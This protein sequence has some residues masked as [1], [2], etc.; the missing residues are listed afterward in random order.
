MTSLAGRLA[1]V[2][3]SASASVSAAARSL[4]A[5]G[6]DIV[7]LGLGEPDFDTPAHIVAAA[8]RA[9]EAGDTRYPPTGGTPALKA[10]VIDKMRRDHGIDVAPGEVIVSNGA[11]QVIFDALMATLEPRDEVLLCAP[12]FGSYESMTALLGGTTVAVDCPERDGFALTPERLEEAITECS[13]WLIL[14]HPSNPTGVVYS[15]D[16][17]RAFGD[18]LAEHPQVSVLS[19][20]IY[21]HIIFDERR[22]VS[23]STA[24]PELRDRT[25]VVNGV[26]KAYAMTGWRIGYGVGPAHLIAA[27]T[28]VQSQI[29]SGA[30][31]VAQAAAVEALTGPQQHIDEFRSAFERRRDLVVDAIAD[32]DE[33]TLATPG[34]AFYAY[35][36]CA[37]LIGAT[38]SAGEVLADDVAVAAYLL[39]NVGVATVPGAAYG[40]S[41][42]VRISTASADNVIADALT[43]IATAAADVRHPVSDTE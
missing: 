4:A 10:A 14:N 42:Y 30:C 40:L 13:R 26:S 34:G 32:I 31:S 9:A 28:T 16:E 3:P 36:G 6:H 27:M 20:E 18:V 33:L 23:F 15:H 12:Y 43:R 25:L 2:V 8:A 11:K 24:C 37:R 17:L 19:D 41:P 7:D 22:F 38:T 35:L 39:D 29:T 1:A 5:A 21:E